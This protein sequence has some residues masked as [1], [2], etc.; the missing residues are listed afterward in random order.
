MDVRKDSGL[1]I[2]TGN[3]INPRQF[4]AN[5]NVIHTSTEQNRNLNSN[6]N[7]VGVPNR[8]RRVISRSNVCGNHNVKKKLT[9][10]NTNAQSL[11]YKVA[12]LRNVIEDKEA[13]VVAVTETWGQP[14]K[15]VSLEII[16]FNNYKKNRGDGRRGGGSALYVSSE[17][18]SYA[19]RELNNLPGDDAV[20]CWIR[21][22]DD[23]KILVGCVYRAP[24]CSDENTAAIMNQI[25]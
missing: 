19:C 20:W 17:L 2:N 13:K 11:Q 3:I 8:Q 24:R 9:C 10:L 14:W 1:S 15:E 16:G 4:S 22:T 23:S 18:K 21:L 12:E 7:F 25:R 6:S 5:T